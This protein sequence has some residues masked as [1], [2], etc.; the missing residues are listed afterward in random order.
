MTSPNLPP[1]LSQPLPGPR[2][3]H[4]LRGWRPGLSQPPASALEAGLARAFRMLGERSVPLI[5]M[6]H[7]R[8]RSTIRRRATGIA[9]GRR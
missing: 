9:G 3:R 6:L 8:T 2:P 5:S 7:S 1:N 4:Q